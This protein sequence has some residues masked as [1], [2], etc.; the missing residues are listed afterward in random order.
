MRVTGGIGCK[1]F[2]CTDTDRGAYR[3]PEVD[4]DPA[5]IRVMVISEAAPRQPSDYYY[6][7]GKPLFAETT[8]QAF[9]DAG[10]AAGSIK[11]LV[12]L[13]FYF[14]TAIKCGKTGYGVETATVRECSRILEAEYDLFNGLRAVM[15]MGDV[16]IKAFNEITRR[17]AGV[18]AVPSGSTYK[19]RGTPYHFRGVRVIPSYL[20]AGPSFFIEKSKRRMIA[21]DI[22]EA[23]KLLGA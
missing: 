1:V 20:Q 4:A 21:Q 14:T 19:I 8:L 17:K 3:I 18:R 12:E 23:L 13:G 11:Q 2:P 5:G 10:L 15:L 22:A 16:A 6:S 7:G 9:H